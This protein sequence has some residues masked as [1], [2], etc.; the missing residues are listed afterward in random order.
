MKFINRAEFAELLGIAKGSTSKHRH[1][2]EPC[3]KIPRGGRHIPMWSIES[4]MEYKAIRDKSAKELKAR[5]A[6]RGGR[7]IT[8]QIEML[9]EPLKHWFN[10]YLFAH[11]RAIKG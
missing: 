2:P 8:Q 3:K 7:T 4:V 9:P 11:V 6:A 1:F 10:I 5:K